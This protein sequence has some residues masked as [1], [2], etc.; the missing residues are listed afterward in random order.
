MPQLSPIHETCRPREDVRRG[1]LADNHFAAQLDQVVRQPGD[2]PIYGD[3]GQFFAITH[4][5]RGLRDLL[6]RIFG[7]LSAA[8]VEGAE[9]G[10]CRYETSFGGGKTH[11]LMALYHLA[12]GA[13]PRNLGE[14]VDA[15]LL[16]ASCQ[17]AAVVGDT[18][19]PVN[20]LDTGGIRSFTLWGE[21]AAQ[22]G[23]DAY[24]KIRRSDEERTAPGKETLAALLGD[25]PTLII[26]DE[27]AGH[28]RQLTSSGNPAVRR[29][30]KAVPVFLK[31]LSEL[32]AGHPWVAV[33]LT[34]ATRSDAFGQETDELRDLL[35]A[36]SADSRA[37]VDEAQSVLARVTG[38]GS[39]LTPAADEEIGEILK[40]RLFESID[41]AAARAAA[42]AYRAFYEGLAARGERLAGGPERPADYAQLIEGSYPF[43]PELIRVLD[44]RIGSIPQFQRARGALK[45]LSEMIARIWASGSDCEILNVADIDYGSSAVLSHLTIGIGRPDFEG[46]AKGDFAG[47]GSFAA[48]VDGSRFA[49]RAPYATRACRT[50]FT[51]S[52]EQV[53]TTGAGRNDYL[54]GTLRVGD[55]PEVIGEALAE[56]ERLAWHLDFDGTRWKFTTEPQPNKI[57]AEEAK[58]LPNTKVA[59][60]VEDRVRRAFPKEGLVDV[61]HFPVGPGSVKDLPRLQLVVL[62]HNDL[63]VGSLGPLPP[64]SRLA[65]ILDRAGVSEDIRA[66]RNGLAFLVADQDAVEAMREQVRRDLAAERV[67]GDRQRMES[68]GVE[69]QKKLQGIAD[70]AGLEARVAINRCYRH[71]YFP[72]A[73]RANN[74]LK[75]EELAA[76]S[77]GDVPT[78]QTRIVVEALK[79]LGKIRT[80]P[81]GIDYLR[82]RAWPKSSPE[83][84]T[85]AVGEAF[86]K[87]HGAQIVLDPT[88]LQTTIRDGTRSGEWIY[89]VAEEQR[90]YGA[91]DPA[92]P[93]KIGSDQYLYTPERA[94]DLGLLNRPLQWENLAEILG[95]VPSLEGRAL[96]GELEKVVGSEPAKKE[97]L[98]LLARAAE[99]GEAARVVVVQGKLEP[100]AKA[101]PPSEI[102]RSA[103]ESLIVMAPEEADRLS[104]VRPGTGRKRT[105]VEAV[106]APGVAF[107]LLIDKASD[108]KE[109]EGFIAVAVTAAAGGTVKDLD[110]LGKA[111]GML[112]RFDIEVETAI[113]LDFKGL[114]PGVE[115]SL[116]GSGR[117]YQKI[118]PVLMSLAKAASQVAGTLRLDIRFAKPAPLTGDDLQSLRKV[119]TGLQPGE[120]RLKG[121]VA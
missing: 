106:G 39:I 53:T 109:F 114:A 107:Q 60:E 101:L 111:I 27:L 17:V 81:M 10:M 84:T 38:P 67:L 75:H 64:P 113:E 108:L 70:K 87:D 42:G 45:L 34:L 69:V 95:R 83:V 25:T 82:T 121:V 44:K 24:E 35:A 55:E 91:K 80:Q 14:F 89:F 65:D 59:A 49:G 46:V 23:A 79:E 98:D 85:Q 66:F 58:N 105:A 77:T 30:A 6:S 72:V 28:L 86:W 76:R 12:R 13:R 5:T 51:H 103:L 4:P 110:L 11:G 54:L 118:E 1:G 117:D 18:L 22:L 68:F 56:T 104:I 47:E 100:G 19:D 73:D 7:R 92:P 74:H 97:V 41:P 57:I 88:I 62:H 96:R 3:P 99:G 2:Y 48:Q 120:I 20:G 112:P 32:A 116:R 8:A 33:V 16:P 26:I 15:R 37:A 52:L 71:L 50:V 78:A 93:V 43:H 61:V 90:A 31:N 115:I 40:R 94:A 36:S 21:L 9:Q 102:K 63:T 29:Q 119:L